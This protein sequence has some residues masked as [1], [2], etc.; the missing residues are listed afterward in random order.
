MLSQYEKTVF[1]TVHDAIIVVDANGTIQS[2]NSATEKITGYSAE[3]LVGKNCR[4]LN[5]TGCKIIDNKKSGI[6]C[7]LFIK[8]NVREKQCQ[9]QNKNGH[10][11]QVLKNA[12][13]IKDKDD[14][15]IGAVET[16][17]DITESI[18]KEN[19]IRHLKKVLDYDYSFQGIIGRS[20]KM[21][22]LFQ[23]IKSVSKTDT[24]VM[25]EG[26]SGTGKELV[27]KAVHDAGPRKGSPFIKVNCAALNEN[28]LESEL[29]GHIK[30]A[31]SG[32]DRDRI[33]RFEAAHKGSIFLDEIGEIPTSTQ[34]K[35]LRVLE[36]KTIER[37]GENRSIHVDVRIITATNRNL[38]QLINEGKIREDFYFRINVF[39]L[40]TPLLKER[41]EDLPLLIG[42]FIEQNIIKGIKEVKG[43]T[44]EAMEKLLK[45]SWPGNVRELRNTIEYAM[46]LCSEELIDTKHLPG[47]IAENNGNNQKQVLK[48][49][50]SNHEREELI[51][52][53]EKTNGNQSKAAEILG[54]SRV[55]VWKRVKKYGIQLNN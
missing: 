6:W 51:Q 30:G 14:K 42:F 37:V 54:V 41:L 50:S 16:L 9:L 1:E 44:R 11:V 18:R 2:V 32:A 27:A 38:E 12:S 47:K 20:Q 25:I 23:M 8:G 17:T 24:P 33:G 55:T 3:E 46:I 36:E 5:C 53:L 28:L 22:N 45:Y 52:A 19:E 13:I 4:I 49:F 31:F 29:F 39:P 26:A 15:A 21:T 34:V 48:N 43:I 40:E 7:G 35:L 10:I